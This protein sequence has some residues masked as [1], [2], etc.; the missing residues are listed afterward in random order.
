MSITLSA[1]R[2]ATLLA[3]AIGIASLQSATAAPSVSN[4]SGEFSHGGAVTISG[5]GFGSRGAYNNASGT[6]TGGKF[7]NFRFKDFEDG[8]LNSNGFFAQ[9][10]G[11]PW[12]ASSSELGIQ[13]GGP[14]NSTRY[15]R[16][17]YVTGELGGLSTNV[18]GAGNQLYTTFK[19]M[20]PAGTQSGKMFRFYADSP[21]YDVYLSTGCTNNMVRGFSECT[22]GSCSGATT[23][24]GSGPALTANQWHRVEV[25]ADSSRNVF[26]V[27]VNGVQAWQ[28]SNWLNSNLGLNG[29]TLD[30]PNML[31]SSSREASCP[32][33][34]SYSYDDIYVDFTQARV[35][36]SDASTW[37]NARKKEVQLPISW[38]DGAITI[39]TNTGTFSAGQTVYVYVVDSSGAVNSQ[40]IA[41]KIGG[42]ATV[43]QPSPPTNVM[44]Q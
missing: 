14:A 8:Q 32:A 43:A 31:D 41:I 1:R 5:S 44:A 9:K 2:N 34:G 24:W 35:E 33:T 21:Q 12:S 38:N 42:T 30:Y 39:R 6:W 15:M 25:W 20:M 16:R 7:L 13:N 37:S 36:I 3:C 10:S 40:G 26:N 22:S 17:S 18:S 29:H 23:E 4:V 28:K 19:F 11:S 27:A